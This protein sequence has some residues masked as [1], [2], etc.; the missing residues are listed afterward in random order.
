MFVL[1]PC[2]RLVMFA[3]PILQV[4][5]EFGAIINADF[6]GFCKERL[7][8]WTGSQSSRLCSEVGALK[9]RGAPSILHSRQCWHSRHWYWIQVAGLICERALPACVSRELVQVVGHEFCSR[10]LFTC[11]QRYLSKL[12]KASPHMFYRRALL[13]LPKTLIGSTFRIVGLQLNHFLQ[14]KKRCCVTGLLYPERL[15]AE[16]C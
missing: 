12:Q 5:F 9:V 8:I 11:S 13:L 6:H 14:L 10:L 7:V 16:T 3:L 2:S 1:K 15:Q 4:V